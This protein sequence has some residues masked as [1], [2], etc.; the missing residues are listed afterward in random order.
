MHELGVL[1][2]AVKTVSDVAKKNGVKKVK[3]MT[4]QVGAESTFVPAFMEKLFPAAKENYPL[5]K[6]AELKIEIIPGKS[7]VIKEIGF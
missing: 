3:F 1:T 5:L 4:L 2:S 6:H 7:L